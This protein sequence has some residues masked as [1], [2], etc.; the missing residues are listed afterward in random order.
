VGPWVFD[1]DPA[2]VRSGLL[3]AFAVAH[4]LSRVAE[5]VDFLTGADRVASA[6][7]T[8]FAVEHVLPWT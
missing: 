3:D 5:G 6:F 4:G 1:P 2:L 7:L 8:A